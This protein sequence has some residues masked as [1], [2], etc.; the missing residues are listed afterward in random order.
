MASRNGRRG[1]STVSLAL[2]FGLV[3]TISVFA[4]VFVA[5]TNRVDNLSKQLDGARESSQKRFWFF[6]YDKPNT[7]RFGVDNLMEELESFNKSRPYLAYVYDCSE[8]SAYLERYLENEGWN[9]TIVAGRNHAWLLV[10]TS[11]GEYTPVEATTKE[12]IQS[13]NQ[14]YE[15]YFNYAHAFKNIIVACDFDSSEFDWWDAR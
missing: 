15:E 12:V 11:D 10:E 1:V 8:M 3:A 5:L 2:F 14:H 4:E 13:D 9:A 6:Y 7:Q